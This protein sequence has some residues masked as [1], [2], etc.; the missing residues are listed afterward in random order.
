M[1]KT[2]MAT[3]AGLAFCGA[4]FAQVK[5][6]TEISS[7]H[8][9]EPGLMEEKGTM[10]GVAGSYTIENRFILRAEGRAAW[11]SV[12]YHNFEVGAPI[13]EPEGTMEGIDDFIGEVRGLVGGG[14]VPWATFYTG[15]GYRYL[16]D[17][18]AGMATSNGSLGYLR[19]SNY[20]YIPIG[21]RLRKSLGNGWSADL[22]PEID[23]LVW[24]KQ[25]SHMDA[26]PG[27]EMVV[28]RQRSGHGVRASLDIIKETKAIKVSAG[29]FIRY[30]D[31]DKSDEHLGF[32]EPNNDSTEIGMNVSV[33]F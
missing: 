14:F 27:F 28:N 32:V 25:V 19:E 20:A 22:T 2:I 29:P 10:Y 31:I 6:G 11:G 8:Y 17:D 23:S 18:Q 9:K 21:V 3:V 4:A 33:I 30:W 1:R 7:I 15:V 13:F 24:G 12:D 16:R 26:I 5:V